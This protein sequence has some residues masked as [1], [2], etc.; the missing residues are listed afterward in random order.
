LYFSLIISDLQPT[1][2]GVCS[3]IP[4][5]VNT[6]CGNS[7]N[8]FLCVA[9]RILYD[10]GARR[11][12]AIFGKNFGRHQISAAACSFDSLERQILRSTQIKAA[13]LR[14]FHSWLK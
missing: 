12:Q 8:S 2:N 10:V 14:I 1:K 7:L 11:H 13:T 5:I 4:R 6:G 3:N 9:Q